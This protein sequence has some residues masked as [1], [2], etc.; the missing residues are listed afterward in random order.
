M[1]NVYQPVVLDAVHRTTY[2]ELES[3]LVSE[4]AKIST[5]DRFGL[6]SHDRSR[7]FMDVLTQNPSRRAA[8]V[9]LA[10]KMASGR[11]HIEE[12][13]KDM[14]TGKARKRTQADLVGQCEDIQ[15]TSYQAIRSAREADCRRMLLSLHYH[16]EK[17]LQKLADCSEEIKERFR[18]MIRHNVFNG[19]GDPRSNEAINRQ[20]MQH[21]VKIA[22]V[23]VIIAPE[24]K[25][26]RNDKIKTDIEVETRQLLEEVDR[27]FSAIVAS[28]RAE[29]YLGMAS[30]LQN[31]IWNG[32]ISLLDC[33]CTLRQSNNYK[34]SRLN[35]ECGH[36]YCIACCGDYE[37][38]C[39]IAGCKARV[40]ASNIILPH[41]ITSAKHLSHTHTD[42][43]VDSIISLIEGTKPYDKVLVFS[44]FDEIGVTIENRLTTIGLSCIRVPRTATAAAQNHMSDFRT[45]KYRDPGWKKV[46]VLDPLDS[47]AA[48]HNLTN[49]H[50]VIFVSPILT[51]SRDKYESA[52]LQAIGRARRHGQTRMVEVYHFVTLN[53]ADIN[54]VEERSGGRLAFRGD[55]LSLEHGAAVR[56]SGLGISSRLY[57]DLE[58]S[59]EVCIGDDVR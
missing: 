27:L 33:G 13:S 40:L 34:S 50:L 14:A 11:K 5:K 20:F 48:G 53:T 30:K 39:A 2:M 24:A 17:V 29:R 44:Q 37:G 54:I 15:D 38:F 16:L 32:N 26:R 25:R 41:E 28:F 4:E 51:E 46:L 55:R 43:K 31:A 3:Q 42:A 9:R 35:R 18:K 22:S 10:T 47:S 21:K 57:S 12:K 6:L 19:H 23:L 49:V 58:E 1:K 52:Y 7:R 56:R 36:S 45:M 8:L 59:Y